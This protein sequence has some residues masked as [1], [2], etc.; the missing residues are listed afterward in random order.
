M[1]LKTAIE[2]IDIEVQALVALKKNLGNSFVEAIETIYRSSGRVVVTGIGKS[3]IVA[4]K[5][6]AT[7]NSTGTPALFMHAADAIHGDLGMIQK[8]DILL[9]LSK[10]GD[11][12][13]IK[14]LVP[15]LKNFGNPL[16]A[17]V[18]NVDSYLGKN[19]NYVLLTPI[20]QE[21]DPNNLAPTAS[22]TAQMALGDAMAIALLKLRGFT[23]TDFAQF[24]PGG[25]LGKQLYLRVSDIYTSHEKPSVEPNDS[26]QKTILEMTS[27]RLGATAV[28]N[29]QQELLGMIT[30]GD[31]RRMLEKGLDFLTIQ[32]KDIMNPTPK[33]IE[34]NTL[35]V[36]ALEQMRHANITQ[37]VVVEEKKY[38]GMIHLHDLLKEGLV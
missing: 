31:L 12:P 9:C 35:A 22:T 25:A 1:I 17:M 33:T 23:S 3:A 27:K 24:H 30:D 26:L 32:A 7:L 2:T 6:V 4:Q 15:L 29:A 18:S 38:L 11:T 34:K 20:K 16:I 36:L 28:V 13:E 19:A 37:L 21:A 10:S 8:D 5:I 14:V